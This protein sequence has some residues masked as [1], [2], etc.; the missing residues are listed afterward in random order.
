MAEVSQEVAGILPILPLLLAGKLGLT[1]SRYFRSSYTIGTEG[2]A[3]DEELDKVI[4]TREDN[5]LDE[6]DR[7]WI[8][9]T[10]D[11]DTSNKHYNDENHG[12]YAIN[13]GSFDIEGALERPRLMEDGN[14]SLMSMG[15]QTTNM[16]SKCTE[17]ASMIT[18][19]T[20]VSTVTTDTLDENEKLKDMLAKHQ[21]TIPKEVFEY[22][23]KIGNP[24]QNWRGV[25]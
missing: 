9:H 13:M 24:P 25:K 23:I 10:E 6:I 22:L 18:D 3:C 4:P 14:E 8:Q 1:V 19:E 5:Y 12:G 15:M 17:G 20:E 11:Y 7:Y 21:D 16:G 2:Y